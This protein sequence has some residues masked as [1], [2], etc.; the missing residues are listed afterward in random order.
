MMM[1]HVLSAS[2]R[3]EVMLFLSSL[4]HSIGLDV[5]LCQ[6]HAALITVAFDVF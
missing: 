4:F 1:A 5:S 6:H 2:Y 3:L